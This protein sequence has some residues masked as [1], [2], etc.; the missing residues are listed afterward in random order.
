MILLCAVADDPN[1]KAFQD[2]M[3]GERWD[4]L[5]RKLEQSKIR[6]LHLHDSANRCAIA[7]GLLNQTL[8]SCD[9]CQLLR[10]AI[11]A[12]CLGCRLC[13]CEFQNQLPCA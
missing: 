8:F 11:F 3:S 4:G 5:E 1:F 10:R 7:S 6:V 13:L 2:I 12:H 9:L